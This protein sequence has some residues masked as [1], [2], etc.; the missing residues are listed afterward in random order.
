MTKTKNTKSPTGPNKLFSSKFLQFL[1]V[2]VAF[3]FTFTMITGAGMAN[4]VGADLE[5]YTVDQPDTYDNTISSTSDFP[6][7]WTEGESY[8]ITTDD[9]DEK[10]YTFDGEDIMVSSDD[11][12]IHVESGVTLE[13][14]GA[15]SDLEDGFVSLRGDNVELVSLD[16]QGAII[17]HEPDSD[18]Y[19]AVDMQGTGSELTGFNL[20]STRGEGG[21]EVVAA[22]ASDV[23]VTHNQIKT[24]DE[25]GIKVSNPWNASHP[26]TYN[27]ADDN[28]ENVVV[29]N[30]LIENTDA[31]IV[32]TN[33]MENEPVD[34]D[35]DDTKEDH[36]YYQGTVKDLDVNHN[37]IKSNTRGVWF[38]AEETGGTT[39]DAGTP[40]NVDISR[41]KLQQNEKAGIYMSLIE[42]ADN[43]ET[44]RENALDVKSNSFEGTEDSIALYISA[45]NTTNIEFNKN[46]VTDY[47]G[48]VSADKKNNHDLTVEGNLFEI[49]VINL[50][51]T[52]EE[53]GST[54]DSDAEN[55][56]GYG[57]QLYHGNNLQVRDNEF[58]GSVD[59]LEESVL[60]DE[61]NLINHYAVVSW[62][63]WFINNYDEYP[64]IDGNVYVENNKMSSLYLGASAFAATNGEI[65][66]NKIDSNYV[67][68]QVGQSDDVYATEA[69]K[70]LVIE[71]NDIKDNTR[72]IWVQNFVKD[73]MHASYNNITGN[74]VGVKNEDDNTFDATYNWWDDGTGP[75]G[76]GAGAGDA[77]SDNVSFSPWCTSE[78]C[79]QFRNIRVDA[80][81]SNVF[82][83]IQEAVN[84][85][86]DGDKIEVA[87]GTYEESVTIDK[88]LTLQAVDEA[89]QTTIDASGEG[90]AL[91]FQTNN[92]DGGTVEVNG[93]TVTGDS[94]STT[95]LTA[96]EGQSE[97][98][99]TEYVVK[100]NHFKDLEVGINAWGYGD[101]DNRV[102]SIEISNNNF[103]SLGDSG[104]VRGTG[105]S[106]EDLASQELDNIDSHA[107][108]IT[109][110]K[111]ESIASNDSDNPGVAVYFS[112]QSDSESNIAANAEV[113]QNEFTSV[114]NSVVVTGDVTNTNISQNSFDA[115]DNGVI[116]DPENGISNGPIDAK[117]NYWGATSPDFENLI[118]EQVDYAPW[119]VNERMTPLRTDD[120]GTIQDAVDVAAEGATVEVEPG[121]FEESV[122]IDIGDLTLKSV[123]GP[124][125]T[126]I[127]A[128]DGNTN[129]ITIQP[130]ASGVTVE[131]FTL[132]GAD[133][134][135]IFVGEFEQ[136]PSNTTIKNNH[137]TNIGDGASEESHG[138]L[139]E[140]DSTGT[141]I[142]GNTI[143]K[144]SPADNR[145]VGISLVS[146]SETENLSAVVEDNV[147]QDI[148]A[149]SENDVI[150]GIEFSQNVVDTA[151]LNNNITSLGSE[152]AKG[153][154]GIALFEGKND[155]GYRYGPK[156][157][158]IKGN[159]IKG[160]QAT[161]SAD[162]PWAGPT[163]IFVGGYE[164]L[165]VDHQVAENQLLNGVARKLY[166]QSGFT[167]A[168][169][170]TLDATY[171]Y[172]GNASE[173]V[174]GED[175]IGNVSYSPWYI[176]SELIV[177]ED[178]N[179]T[180]KIEVTE[181]ISESVGEIGN[182]TVP[183]GLTISSDDPGWNGSM[184][185]PRVRPSATATPSRSGYS[186]D[187][188]EV[189]EVG[190]PGV[191]LDLSK[192][193]KIVFSGEAG[194]DVGYSYDGDEFHRI[195]DECEYE[196]NQTWADSMVYEDCYYNN[197]S[198][199]D[200]TVWTKHFTEFITF[201][202]N[203]ETTGGGGST[204]ICQEEDWNCTEW[205][206]CVD[207]TRTRDCEKTVSCYDYDDLE[208]AETR[209][210]QEETQE[211]G[212]VE[213]E[214]PT[215]PPPQPWEPCINGTQIR[216]NYRCSEDTG[217][218]CE[219]FTE[220]RDCTVE[221][222]V[223][224]TPTGR[225]LQN[226]LVG[227]VGLIAVI[228]FS[229]VGFVSREGK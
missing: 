130:D 115:D 131:G 141:Q 51:G 196:G 190:Y 139:V 160:I 142:V 33:V 151:V 108:T 156:G 107:A 93:F 175:Y 124:E 42:E 26:W 218:E 119:Y 209:S 147:I 158:T 186:T 167:P 105:V 222:T 162:D 25:A 12:T 76:A 207:G 220:E 98:D 17:S 165:G 1:I 161:E 80:D 91:Q 52:N 144:I 41:N 217:Y 50:T 70:G 132:Q 134:R 171:N 81:G 129:V 212:Q 203:E 85:A 87:P 21:S 193:V 143:D 45:N 101:Y 96:R 155:S 112:P 128:P 164:V 64:E 172:W 28:T 194:K 187:V 82:N 170:D 123:A 37:T 19:P 89:E 118:S 2:F 53:S 181:N 189:I 46:N 100:N 225:F 211:E 138:I 34:T 5:G 191:K 62:T 31:G 61:K 111:F 153:A 226:P 104:N 11:V 223:P 13:Y 137:I 179:G 83:S 36:E 183:A 22:R 163:S 54:K 56:I 219:E 106:L 84:N 6:D 44:S 184:A 126:T 154:H 67:G 216:Y 49:P 214:C 204:T 201:E 15:S 113:S 38:S 94:A 32:V 4:E 224:T 109:N 10:T 95:G 27:G 198:S 125:E 14:T 35:N 205:S 135:G 169:A 210:C 74:E 3:S 114:A 90:V 66:N 78:A 178:V 57:V 168:E 97:V 99:A 88:A 133:R 228:L 69:V 24:D 68:I 120:S 150:Y 176:D 206:E 16:P 202:E 221:Q 59:E 127:E 71:G 146:Q 73:G 148:S 29:A 79:D 72:G 208:P 188:G 140:Q 197:Y 102:E 182:V 121:T 122:N 63:A 136:A 185:P 30:N 8:K 159:I 43:L 174:E 117:Y 157:F 152:D 229:F 103:T 77:V 58:V 18:W 215:C 149:D 20:E 213:E 192:A 173:P 145:A 195:T 227:I 166:D 60:K 199:G 110:N 9:Q 23:S 86:T 177:S 55:H 65:V 75:S 7:T 116:V 200:L 47:K 48:G 92:V 39:R 180:K 40:Q